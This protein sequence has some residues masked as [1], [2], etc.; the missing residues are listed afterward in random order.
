MKL[1]K[2]INSRRARDSE[3]GTGGKYC[4]GYASASLAQASLSSA[5]KNMRP[6]I[7]M[8]VDCKEAML[9]LYYLP[10][11]LIADAA[12]S[13]SE[14]KSRPRTHCSNHPRLPLP[15][16]AHRTKHR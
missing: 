13:Q 2:S 15:L 1:S 4:T 6:I 7:T 9:M 12:R 5:L 16:M 8:T 3:L 14:M 10:Q 11:L